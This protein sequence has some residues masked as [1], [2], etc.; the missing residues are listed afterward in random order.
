MGEVIQMQW[1]DCARFPDYE[2][3]ECGDVWRHKKVRNGPIGL[4]KPTMDRGYR[5]Y[6]LRAA[7]RYHWVSAHQLVAEAFIGP[8][9]FE[10][11][12]VCHNDG[13][14]LNTHYSNLRWDTH[15]ANHQDRIA[16]GTSHRGAANPSAKLSEDDVLQDDEDDLP[17]WPD[18][19]DCA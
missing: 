11:A 12:E 3:N 18:S 16:H 7:S 9:P 17:K 6:H 5:R 1:R 10:G 13:V 14:R 4:I 8:K 19:G 2:V 15:K